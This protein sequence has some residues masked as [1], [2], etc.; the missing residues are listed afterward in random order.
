MSAEQARLAI[1]AHAA[2]RRPAST[3]AGYHVLTEHEADSAIPPAAG[4]KP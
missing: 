3:S 1:A 4:P 2:G